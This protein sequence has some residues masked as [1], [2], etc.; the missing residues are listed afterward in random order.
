[1]SAKLLTGKNLADEIRSETRRDAE[2]LRKIGK[3]AHLVSVLVRDHPPSLLY[4][5]NQRAACKELGIK[6]TLLHLSEDSTQ[7]EVVGHLDALADNKNITGIIVTL[8]L[9]EHLDPLAIQQHLDPLK[10]VEGMSPENLGHLFRGRVVLAPCTALS[11]HRLLKSVGE[12]TQGKEVCIVGH[13]EIVGKPITMLMLAEGATVTTC[14]EFTKD[15]AAHTRG[16]DILFTAVGKADLITKDMVK[17]G[18]IVIDI[19]VSK[20]EQLDE[21]GEPL[22]DINGKIRT[23]TKGDVDFD[24]VKEIAS[25]ISP[26]PGG[27]GPVTVAMLLANTVKAARL[28]FE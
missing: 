21:N 7:D 27:V 5:K 14:H 16:A 17:P 4:I 11:A 19:G 25:Y 9:P 3:H 22:R 24:A 23:K 1:M 2:S 18:A 15:L 10:D 6:Y 20:V 12:K 8:P 28:Q 13:S 26:V